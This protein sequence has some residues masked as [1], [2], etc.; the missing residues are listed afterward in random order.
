MPRVPGRDSAIR[1]RPL[2]PLA[3]A[4]P[5]VPPLL[6]RLVETCLQKEPSARYRDADELLSDCID[7]RSRLFQK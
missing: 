1:T 7:A 5:G 2:S 4:C 6:L 3:A